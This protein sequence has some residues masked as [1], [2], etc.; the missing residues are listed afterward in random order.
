MGFGWF[1]SEREM[2]GERGRK[3]RYTFAVLMRPRHCVARHNVPMGV[4]I[5]RE[6]EGERE[7]EKRDAGRREKLRREQTKERSE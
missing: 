5:E 6:K 3:G 4:F 2:K 1:L 7:G